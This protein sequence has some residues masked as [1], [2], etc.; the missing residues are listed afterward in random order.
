MPR[1]TRVRA[2]RP[3]S[4][5]SG[6]SAPT[7]RTPHARR[8]P[9]DRPLGRLGV[10]LDNEPLDGELLA[11]LRR[12]AV[13]LV[14]QPPVAT[15]STLLGVVLKV[16]DQVAQPDPA[17]G[18]RVRPPRQRVHL[19]RADRESEH[20]AIRPRRRRKRGSPEEPRE[21]ESCAQTNSCRSV[22]SARR[23]APRSRQLATSLDLVVS[24]GIPGMKLRGEWRSGGPA[25][26]LRAAPRISLGL[27][28]M[29]YASAGA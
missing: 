13:E 1:A 12:A 15:G 16:Q 10:A 11:L 20:A 5:A 23:R 14:D 2:W 7:A 28:P 21:S 17:L 25:W 26:G 9:A 29:D 3:A 4:P 22:P 19:R 18:E 6:T 24:P 27:G 8:C